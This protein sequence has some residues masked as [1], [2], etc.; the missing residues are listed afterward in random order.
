MHGPDYKGI[1]AKSIWG[2]QVSEIQPF[3]DSLRRIPKSGV[4]NPLKRP[5]RF[6]PLCDTRLLQPYSSVHG[7]CGQLQ[8]MHLTAGAHAVPHP[9]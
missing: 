1:Y 7:I 2:L 5:E 9:A 6:A 4:H 8:P 3:V